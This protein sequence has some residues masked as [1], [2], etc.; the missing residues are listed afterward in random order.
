MIQWHIKGADHPGR[1]SGGVA[2]LAAMTAK[3]WGGG[4]NGK[5]EGDNGESGTS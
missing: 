4:D 2:K 1:Q 5:N 3:K